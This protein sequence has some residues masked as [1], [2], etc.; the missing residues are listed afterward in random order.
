MERRVSRA[1]VEDYARI[2]KLDLLIGALEGTPPTCPV[3]GGELVA[4]EGR[5]DPF[6]WRCATQDCY[7]RSIDQPAPQDGLLPCATCGEPLEFR[8]MP[9]GPHWRCTANNRHRQRVI[10]SHLRLPRMRELIPRGDLAQ[11]ERALDARG[12]QLRLPGG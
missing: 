10:R 7:S 1:V 2:L 8:Q 3:C 6:Y 5:R 4:A 11:V 12:E 9:T